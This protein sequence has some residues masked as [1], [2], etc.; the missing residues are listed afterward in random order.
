MTG[1]TGRFLMDAATTN[2]ERLPANFSDLPIEP[3]HTIRIETPAGA[4]FGKPFAR[5]PARVLADVLSGKVSPAAARSAYGVAVMQAGH[6]FAIDEK[7]TAALRGA[8]H[9]K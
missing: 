4:G 3:G 1:R 2:E 9:A 7:E 6:S 5:A 8:S